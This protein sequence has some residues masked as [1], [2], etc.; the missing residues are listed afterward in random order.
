MVTAVSSACPREKDRSQTYNGLCYGLWKVKRKWQM[1]NLNKGIP[2]LLR[3]AKDT[4]SIF[5]CP[6]WEDI[7]VEAMENQRGKTT[8]YKLYVFS[9][10]FIS[11]T[12]KYWHFFGRDFFIKMCLHLANTCG[13]RKIWQ[14]LFTG[15][16]YILSSQRKMIPLYT[17]Y[18]IRQLATHWGLKL[19]S[20]IMCLVAASSTCRLYRSSYCWGLLR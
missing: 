16:F 2:M 11:F 1:L 10:I 3:F 5:L 14:L 8:Q 12:R 6:I 7:Q 4:I 18:T 15:L 19:M 20:L 13:S 17:I 9:N